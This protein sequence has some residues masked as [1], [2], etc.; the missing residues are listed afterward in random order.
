MNS[1]IEAAI[2]QTKK[3]ESLLENKFSA[4]GRG[5][6]EK[7]SSVEYN[8]PHS[9]VSRAR[10]IASIRNELVHEDGFIIE[11][12]DAFC[13]NCEDIFIELNEMA[14]FTAHQEE[15]YKI[16]V[17]PLPLRVFYKDYDSHKAVIITG[18]VGVVFVGLCVYFLPLELTSLY[19]GLVFFFYMLV[20]KRIIYSAYKNECKNYSFVFYKDSF[21]KVE[22]GVEKEQAAKIYYAVV[23]KVSLIGSSLL[24]IIEVDAG[25]TEVHL[26]ELSGLPEV[27]KEL[28][29][30]IHNLIFRGPVR[31]T[32]NREPVGVSSTVVNGSLAAVVASDLAV[33]ST[34]NSELDDIDEF[35]TDSQIPSDE[36]NPATGYLMVG[37]VGGVDTV[38]NAYGAGDSF[39][40]MDDSF[41]SIDDSSMIL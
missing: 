15:V 26:I 39:S 22:A 3:I 23:K 32:K 18:L 2:K 29:K 12:A 17:V 9:L 33:N 4:Q 11:D 41:S 13:K 37:G 14:P 35:H 30:K 20:I 5:L 38:G 1:P 25:V 8:L 24:E 36:F 31:H 10:Q 27:P 40:S 19:I 28:C 6:H 7:V 34:S 21:S 16:P